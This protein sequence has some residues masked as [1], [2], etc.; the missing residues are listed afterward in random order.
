MSELTGDEIKRYFE[1]VKRNPQWYMF[2]SRVIKELG[3][4]SKPITIEQSRAREHA[5]F[6]RMKNAPPYIFSTEELKLYEEHSC[7]ESK[8]HD[9]R[10]FSLSE[11]T[12]D[13]DHQG[14][15][16]V[17]EPEHDETQDQHDETQDQHDEDQDQHSENNE[18]KQ[19][20]Y[21]EL[22]EHG[23]AFRKRIMDKLLNTTASSA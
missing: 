2:Q 10:P 12:S 9:T 14:E 20:E 18:F 15:P 17:D 21:D 11:S 22:K 4:N 13:Q 8:Y 3:I 5:Y 7:I 19:A 16:E 23:Y 6:E 1:K